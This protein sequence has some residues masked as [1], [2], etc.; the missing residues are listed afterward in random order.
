MK[1]VEMC[2]MTDPCILTTPAFRLTGE[3]FKSAIWEGLTDFC[4]ICWKLKS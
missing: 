4:D 3:D 1:N 2:I